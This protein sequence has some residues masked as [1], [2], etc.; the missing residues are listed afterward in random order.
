MVAWP[1]LSAYG[2]LRMT[3]DSLRISVSAQYSTQPTI[4]GAWLCVRMYPEWKHYSILHTGYD[5]I[6]RHLTASHYLSIRSVRSG[7]IC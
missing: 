3:C 2:M 1:F 7:T 4:S 6:H 5:S